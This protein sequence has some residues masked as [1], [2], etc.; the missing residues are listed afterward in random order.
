M[1]NECIGYN[2]VRNEG[3]KM[4]KAIYDSHFIPDILYVP[5]RGGAFL[6]NVISEYFKTL[7]PSTNIIY[8]G[9]S[10][11]SY[12]NM[13]QEDTIHL[14]GWTYEPHN[15]KPSSKVLFIDDIFDTGKTLNF[16][17]NIV[18]QTVERNNI[19]IAVLNHKI[20]EE[21]EKLSYQ[22]SFVSYIH[23]NKKEKQ[24]TWI[25][26]TSHELVGL[27]RKELSQLFPID[28]DEKLKE[29]LHFIIKK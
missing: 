26:Y 6:A 28:Q 10:A 9:V 14:A 22:P 19:K 7:L 24:N 23:N 16:L 5:L 11:N 27:T 29:A 17:C 12:N 8:A 4:A 1:D 18:E 3:I 15:L 2:R 21:N 25:H 13:K 20:T